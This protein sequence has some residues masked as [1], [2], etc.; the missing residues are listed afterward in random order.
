MKINYNNIKHLILFIVLGIGFIILS[1]GKDPLFDE[2][3]TN[4]IKVVLKG[5]YES[6]N[7]KLWSM[8]FPQDDS[9]DDY[10]NSSNDP[11]QEH[12]DNRMKPPT[13]YM[14]DLAELRIQSEN[15]KH[16]Q[17]FANY[18]KVYSQ[19]MDDNDPFFNGNGIHYRNDDVRPDFYW[20]YVRMYIRKMI[21]DNAKEY[22]QLDDEVF[23]GLGKWEYNKNLEVVFHEK[24]TEGLD[25]NQLQ[26]KTYYDNLLDGFD[27]NRVFPFDILIEDGLVFNRDDD[28]TVLE[29]RIVVKNFIKK[30]E[31]DYINN[32]DKYHY[33]RHYYALSD[34]LRDVKDEHYAY[35]SLAGKYRY[36]NEYIGGNIIAIARTYVKGATVTLTGDAGSNNCYVVAINS[37]H[38]ITEYEIENRARPFVC[39]NPKT[40]DQL[41][42][43][44][45]VHYFPDD[46]E[47]ILD[48]Y[49]N[50]EKYKIDYNNFVDCV[51]TED[52]QYE[53]EWTDYNARLESFKIPP[54]ATWVGGAESTFSLTDVPVGE[55][56]KIY[57][58]TEILGTGELP[59]IFSENPIGIIT[60][61]EDQA[62]LTLNIE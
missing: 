56:Y 26:N 9:V 10:Q 43:S 17:S 36:Y 22:Y 52:G 12:E 24:D 59:G 20:A 35:D 8:E 46:I 21:I 50:Y 53:V 47:Y 29:I 32:D 44:T 14:L 37:K 60:V 62:G 38:D 3:A 23:D 45:L 41:Q 28:E 11:N 25:F 42:G 18:R 15:K 27:E 4:R 49:L 39:D 55:T 54:L 51:N 5:T 13:R 2:L 1:C 34:W 31:F 6:N 61:T 40:P 33:V 7:P 16:V 19:A 58:S 48:N 57:I 30:Y